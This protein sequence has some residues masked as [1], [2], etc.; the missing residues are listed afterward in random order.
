MPVQTRHLAKVAS[1]ALDKK[2]ALENRVMRRCIRPENAEVLLPHLPKNEEERLHAIIAGDFIFCDLVCA[3]VARH[4]APRR[5]T[6]AT[7]SLSLKNVAALEKLA[8]NHGFPIDLL[9]SHYFEKTNQA[10]FA[11]LLAVRDRC[12]LIRVRIARSHCKITLFDYP[13]FPLVIESS[14]NLRSS[15]NLEQVSIFAD[16]ELLDFHLQWI[17]EAAAATQQQP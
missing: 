8:S 10:I 4:G 5:L 14:A 16:R 1:R 3:V 11:A 6:C 13:D 7:L 17:E 9:L 15:R 2:I 12:P